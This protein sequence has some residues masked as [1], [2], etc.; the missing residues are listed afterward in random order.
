MTVDTTLAPAPRDPGRLRTFW[1]TIGAV[2]TRELRWRMRG[3][4]AFVVATIFVLLLG[5]LVFGIYQVLY[6]YALGVARGQ[7][8]QQ[9][10]GSLG[11]GFGDGAPLAAEAIS[12]AASVQIGQAIFVGMLGVLTVLIL[13]VVP[14][15]TAGVVS[16][17]RERQTM[18]LLVTTPISTLG[19][20]FAKLLGSLAYVLLLI[21]A[22]VPL[23]S[24][25]FAFGGVGPEDVVRAYIVVLAVAFGMG[26]IGMFISALLGRTQ[27]ATV[28]SYLVVFGLV[29]G[30]FALHT[31]L[32]ASS[33]PDDWRGNGEDARRSA[34]EALVW[35]NPVAA[36]ADVICTAMPEMGLCSYTILVRGLPQGA[37]E[38]P[39]DALWPRS[40]L[41]FL[42][43]GCTL[44][45]LSTQLISPSRGLRSRRRQAAAA[46]PDDQANAA[47]DTVS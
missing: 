3:R 38:P 4:R 7:L 43:L 31:W 47:P 26:S 22:S 37:N 42:V 46:F 30:T 24:I 21:I 11:D 10:G 34:P 20:L 15:L 18:E 16:S 6:Q 2:L 19:M 25:V 23:M 28:V 39:R 45:A 41:A 13:F 17:E 5:L 8:Q 33:V 9:L 29:V 44:T 32:Y 12:G 35:L 40:V 1:T 36:D 27:I 14:A